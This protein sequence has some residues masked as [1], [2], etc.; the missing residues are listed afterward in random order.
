MTPNWSEFEEFAS[1]GCWSD[2]ALATAATPAPSRADDGLVTTCTLTELTGESSAG[3]E[4]EPEAA[5][6]LCTVGSAA[7]LLLTLL[8]LFW[9]KASAARRVRR[10]V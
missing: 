3:P 9:M 7:L 4:T 10:T 5:A 8:G 6:G 2:V 1:R